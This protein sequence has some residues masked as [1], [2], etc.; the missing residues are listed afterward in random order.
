[1]FDYK[2]L[3]NVELRKA[4]KESVYHVES[5]L[6]HIDA[7]NW[8]ELW[9]TAVS[10]H[11]ENVTTTWMF[12]HLDSRIEE[13]EE[14]DDTGSPQPWPPAHL[15]NKIWWSTV[16]DF[17]NLENAFDGLENIFLVQD[18]DEENP[19]FQSF[20]YWNIERPLADLKSMREILLA[21]RLPVGAFAIA[22]CVF[23]EILLN[24]LLKLQSL[25]LCTKMC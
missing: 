24:S 8:L 4:L 13:A 14:E 2:V 19:L 25:L 21:N 15:E 6:H 17:S 22:W 11:L 12:Q 9:A 10:N 1:M 18:L 20:H 5:L 16:A 3:K 23:A 7:G